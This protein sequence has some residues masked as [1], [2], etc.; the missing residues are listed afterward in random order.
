VS[1][2]LAIA[3]VTKALAQILDSAVKSAVDSSGAVTQR[4][5]AGTKT[6]C[7]DLFL[8]QVT[9]NAAM[10]NSDLPTR[11][12]PGQVVSRPTS[13]LDLHYLMSFYG[14]D[15]K[16]EPQRMLG[17]VVRSLLAEPGLTRERI[18]A[19]SKDDNGDKMSG[20]NLA[21]A[22]EQ[23]KL[24]PQSLTLDELSRI[25][26]IFYQVPYVLSVAYTATV[27]TIESE[28][29][30]LATQPVLQ[31]GQNDTGVETQLGPFPQL[32]SWHIGEGDDDSARLRLP[33]YPSARLGTVL[34]LRGRNLGGDSVAVRLV[35][36]NLQSSV[37]DL[38]VTLIPNRPGEMKVSIPNATADASKWVAGIYSVA[39]AIT[40]AGVTR[41]TNTLPLPFAPQISAI[42]AGPRDGSGNVLV[43]VTPAPL[44]L[45]AQAAFLS[46]PDRDVA[47]NPRAL[48]TDPLQFAVVN[49]AAGQAVV[50]LRV[51]GVDSLQF[52]G[53]GVPPKPGLAQQTIQFPP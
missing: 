31:R 52:K 41:S 16:F 10:R 44:V 43:T 32:D 35:N 51:D 40:T 53:Q 21:D 38:P 36:P 4:P 39:V 11:N 14:D 2:Y 18:L 49:P 3:T 50:R 47:A 12:A 6:A 17:A 5:D 8:Y 20:S 25:W 9:P 29:P 1:N 24:T 30:V 37:P 23:V 46:L 15:S 7:V 22:V 34:T 26:S 45:R 48:A 13:A 28:E 42:A 27:V 33:S 19:V